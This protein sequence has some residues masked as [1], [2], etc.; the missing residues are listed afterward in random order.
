MSAPQRFLRQR[1]DEEEVWVD[2]E[3]G[4]FFGLNETGTA[5]LEA[6]RVGVRDTSALA[7]RLK[8]EFDA[9]RETILAEV[10]AF[11]AEARERGLLEA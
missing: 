2:L 3:G 4:R 9:P 10:T 1:I 7:D 8:A 6:W 5:I 11:L